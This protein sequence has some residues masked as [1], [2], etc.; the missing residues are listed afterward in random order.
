[1]DWDVVTEVL[2]MAREGINL[3][4]SAAFGLGMFLS[5]VEKVHVQDTWWT[6]GGERDALRRLLNKTCRLLASRFHL[7]S[8]DG[9]PGLEVL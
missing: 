8:V 5:G 9:S 6:H 1:M 2:M 4:E 3:A 7:T